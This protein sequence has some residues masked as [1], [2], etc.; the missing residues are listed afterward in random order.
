M[1]TESARKDKLEMLF[2]YHILDDEKELLFFN[3]KFEY[4]D[5]LGKGSFG[6]VIAAKWKANSNKLVAVKIFSLKEFK[7]DTIEIFNREGKLTQKYIHNSILG[8]L[9]VRCDNDQ[10]FSST[11]HLYLVFPLMRGR[12]LED[13]I[14]SR[15]S[16]D[17]PFEEEEISQ[18]IGNTIL[19]L[20]YLNDNN[21]IHRDIKPGK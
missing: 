17:L 2:K 8:C 13:V 18:I 14:R 12:T 16:R 7:P 1:N 10:V 6:L 4:I 19:G 3:E 5:V 20:Q 11:G 21:I 9:S 15:F